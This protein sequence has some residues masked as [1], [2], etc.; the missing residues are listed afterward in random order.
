MRRK[1][2]AVI[3]LL[4]C[5]IIAFSTEAIAIRELD[6]DEIYIANDFDRNKYDLSGV[7]GELNIVPIQAILQDEEI[8]MTVEEENSGLTSAY[9]EWSSS[10]PDVISCTK[11]GKIKG[12]L[13]GKAVITVKAKSGKAQD[14]ITV[15]CAKKLDDPVSTTINLPFAWSGKIP[16]FFSMQHFFFFDYFLNLLKFRVMRITVKGYYG[17]FFYVTY[18]YNGEECCGYMWSN[19]LP[20]KTAS[21]Q[22][23]KQLSFYETVV[24]C[25]ESSDDKLT[26]DYEGT[27][28][29]SV[30]D[31]SVVAF[32]KDT[33]EITAKKPGTAIISATVGTKTLNCM[34]FSV[35]KWYETETSTSTKTVYVRDIPAITGDTVATLSKGTS[36]TA[37]GDLE[38]GMGWIHITSGNVSGFIQVSDFPGIDYLMSEYHYYDKGFEVR[39]DSPI[40]K[41]YDYASVLN[42]I[43][44]ENFNLKVCPYV[45]SYTST[46]DQCKIWSYGSVYNNNLYAVCP[47]TG[48]HNSDSCLLRS[49]V[50]RDMANK[51]GTGTKVIARCLW[52]G[53]ILENH[54]G[55]GANTKEDVIIFTTRNATYGIGNQILDLSSTEIYDARLYEIVHETGHLL[56]LVDGYCNGI[57]NGE[58][59]CSNT[60]CY[61]C[62]GQTV[63]QCIMVQSFNPENAEVV[64][65]DECNSI[66]KDHLKNHH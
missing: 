28:K 42:N 35:S 6:F 10:N 22:I 29:W 31:E 12:L 46:A 23:F 20:A 14:S 56:G 24:F 1:F 45:E 36:M 47:E 39:Y 58:N 57:S 50:L 65:C 7:V 8:Q 32:D 55:S 37:N 27:V 43:M 44:M 25:G 33:G 34:V 21:D 5:F 2:V 49:T 13:Q 54:E 53:H 26:T 18:K 40:N 16:V 66:I 9:I 59:H 19:F 64:F 60:N 61:R 3:S 17:S 11:G 62:N 15:Y 63:P 38:N 4:L 30:S 41:I 48:Y 52:T 51:K